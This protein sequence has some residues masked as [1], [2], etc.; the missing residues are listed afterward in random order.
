[1][2]RTAF[3]ERYRIACLPFAVIISGRI[4]CD[5]I[6]IY[7]VTLVDEQYRPVW[8]PTVIDIPGLVPSEA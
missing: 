8:S 7:N 3:R 2:S 6:P 1:M 4:D 5:G